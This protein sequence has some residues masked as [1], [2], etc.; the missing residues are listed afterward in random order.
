MR[1]ENS[2]KSNNAFTMVELVVAL[3]IASLLLT[4]VYSLFTRGIKYNEKEVKNL[5]AIQEM[6]FIVYNLRSDLRT[7]AEFE[8]TPETLASYDNT[9]KT[10]KFNVVNGVDDTGRLLYSDVK[11]YMKNNCVMKEF[12]E[13][14]GTS[15]GGMKT[16]QLSQSNKIK[17]FKIEML[18]ID[19]NA[20]TIPRKPGKPP[21][22]FRVKV[23][24][25]TN[26]RLEVAINI[27]STYMNKNPNPVEK[28]WVPC[29]KIKPITPVMSIISSID[30]IK[31]STTN[32]PSFNYTS[33]GIKVDDT[34]AI[35]DGIGGQ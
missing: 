6:V 12:R 23:L 35:P 20:V 31:F 19:G 28:F 22:F 21:L 18:D 15:Y 29:W 30:N 11:Y 10:L 3:A 5:A 34:M 7:F 13:L 32:T 8:N 26:T 2:R 16:R 4:V 27:C 25:A 9:T 14:T 1:R 17:E 24:H 33:A